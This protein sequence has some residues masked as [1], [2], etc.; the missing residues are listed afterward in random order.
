MDLF[1]R[2]Y[3]EESTSLSKYVKK[4]MFEEYLD[5]VVDDLKSKYTYEAFKAPIEIRTKHVIGLRGKPLSPVTL[6]SKAVKKNYNDDKENGSSSGLITRI[7][8]FIKNTVSKIVNGFKEMFGIKGDNIFDIKEFTN[9]R[10][11][12]VMINSNYDAKMR[13]INKQ[14]KMGDKIIHAI[15]SLPGLDETKV[16]GFVNGVN[17]FIHSIPKPVAMFGV[18]GAVAGGM[19]LAKNHV[20]ALKNN[21]DS[22]I[23]QQLKLYNRNIKYI[24]T[25]KDK[26]KAKA[27]DDVLASMSLLTRMQVNMYAALMGAIKVGMTKLKDNGGKVADTVKNAVGQKAPEN[28]KKTLFNRGSDNKS[29]N[30]KQNNSGF[31]GNNKSNKSQNNKGGLFK[32]KK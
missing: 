17:D 11:F 31:F 14:M 25:S 7:I 21:M 8:N 26:K 18:G 27:R 1:D 3:Y 13:E 4:Y 12:N 22:E 30:N 2:I 20:E 32:N 23:D 15:G 29:K 19:M 28:V 24:F 16:R 6:V 10:D 9:S 5:M